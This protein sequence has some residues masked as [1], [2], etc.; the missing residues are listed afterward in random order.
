M[1]DITDGL[2]VGNPVGSEDGKPVGSEVGSPDGSEVGEYAALGVAATNKKNMRIHM[3]E[4]GP[5]LIGMFLIF[6]V[7]RILMSLF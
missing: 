7:S 4:W 3:E 5:W 1:L 2:G 6:I